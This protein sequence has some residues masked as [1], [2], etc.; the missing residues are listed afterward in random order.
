MIG[1][2]Y[3]FYVYCCFDFLALTL[4]LLLLLLLLF[5]C[6]F[7]CTQAVHRSTTSRSVFCL[8]WSASWFV[9]GGCSFVLA[10]CTCFLFFLLASRAHFSCFLFLIT[11]CHLLLSLSRGDFSDHLRGS[12]LMLVRACCSLSLTSRTY[13][14]CS[15]LLITGCCL[16]LVKTHFSYRYR[17]LWPS[18]FVCLWCSFV[19]DV[20]VFFS[21]LLALLVGLACSLPP[22]SRDFSGH[23][24]GS[25]LMLVRACCAFALAHFP[26]YSSCSL[27]LT[28]LAVFCFSCDFS[29][30][31][32][33]WFVYGVRS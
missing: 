32:S 12:R 26:T 18:S 28:Q 5:A 11:A 22:D 30:R 31:L 27:L 9:L 3:V 1:M 14:S 4:L 8:L 6:L 23:L 21:C 13:S 24:R 25:R 10:S 2:R 16:L 7:A 33:S 20:R 15:L 29:Y 17:L 19:A